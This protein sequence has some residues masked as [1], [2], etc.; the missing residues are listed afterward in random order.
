MS[1]AERYANRR[2]GLG[3]T[4]LTLSLLGTWV[5][6]PLMPAAIVIG[7]AASSAKYPYAYRKWKET[8]RIGAIHLMC[9]YSLYLWLG[10]Y[11]AVGA[12]GAVLYGMMLKAKAIGEDQSRNNLISIFQ[13]QPDSVWIRRDEV[14]IEIPFERL[15]VGD[16]I[17]VSAG[18][19][20]PVDG[21]V[22]E[23]AATIDQQVLTG[24]SQ[25]VE[26]HEGDRV[27][28]ATMLVSGRVYVVVEKTSAETTAGKIAEVLNRT[29]RDAKPA[30]ISAVET[31]DK[32]ALP[33][34]AASV[35]TFPFRGAAGAISLMGANTTTASYM[36]GSLAMLNFINLAA[37]SGVLVK[38]AAAL[39]RL[40]KVDVILF[41]KTGT[42]T[43][44]Q[45]EVV[46]IYS[47]NGLST[48]Q[49]LTFAAAAEARQTHPIAKAILDH[50]ESNSLRLPVIDDAHYEV[51]Y[52]IKVR[53]KVGGA[54]PDGT[55]PVIRVGSAR[56]M[57]MEGLAAVAGVQPIVEQCKAHG[58]SLV[59]VAVDDEIAGCIE[60]KP[61]IRPEA[62][63]IVRGLRTR[64]IE[65]YIVSG[66]HEA[67]TARLAHDLGM[68]GY[69]A[70]T[71]PEAKGGIVAKL[72]AEGR[73]VCFIG[74]G[75]NDAIAMRQA[76]VSISL[77]G[78]T[79]VATDTAQIVLMEG[80]L[81]QLLNLFQLGSEFERNLK[82]N[83]RF[84]SSISIAA[85]AGILFLGST[86]AATEVLYSVSL[87]GGLAIAMKPVF[88]RRE[89]QKQ[90]QSVARALLAPPQGSTAPA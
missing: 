81:N 74:D 56:F 40:G 30:S 68:T 54:S 22:V 19:V 7:L 58:H 44:E 28:A 13:L 59:L 11:A 15:V 33:T 84:T 38:D 25:P 50:A 82:D 6:S 14:E 61:S 75:I 89:H 87:F 78:A 86:F 52:G 32:L 35:L 77:R 29:M 71:L 42:L 45:P 55:G 39:E 80:S 34:L 83:I 41:D 90:S 73:R 36:S 16:T 65:M 2:L 43:L 63:G 64:G 51:G 72:Q 57:D 85:V 37:R 66:D 9:V 62:L 70:G 27:L 24:E 21:T 20:I 53:L 12:L 8:K 88:D 47:L 10:G 26:C 1:D 60:L 76:Q 31:A 79:S 23:G 4:A 69:F 46:Q 48:D 18:Q 3:L 49:V 17:V 67:P 5:F